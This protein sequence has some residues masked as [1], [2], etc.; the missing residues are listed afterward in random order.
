MDLQAVKL[1]GSLLA[2]RLRLDEVGSCIQAV[3]PTI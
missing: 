2:S 1:A 3:V